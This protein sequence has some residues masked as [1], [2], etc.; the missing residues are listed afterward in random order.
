MVS[1]TWAGGK[2]KLGAGNHGAPFRL[3]TG[4]L[5]AP[6]WASCLRTA[7]AFSPRLRR[8]NSGILPITGFNRPP[9]GWFAMGR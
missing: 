4:R 1:E 3:T 6:Q 7:G 9:A 5:G 8:A 2:R